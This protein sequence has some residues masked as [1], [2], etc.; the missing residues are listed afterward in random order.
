MVINDWKM[1]FDKY[2][3]LACTVPCD[4][5]SVLYEHGYIDDPYYGTNEDKLTALSRKDSVFYSEL[6]LNKE[7]LKCE[8]IDL[9]FY[10][11]D[12]ICDIYFNG[13][14]LDSVKNM[15]RMYEYDV[16]SLAKEKNEIKLYIKAPI[17]YFEKEEANH[18]LYMNDSDTLPGAAH[19][20][21]AFYM[22]GWD[23]A[24]K[25]PN[26][27][28][29]RPVTVRC[30]NTDK[31]EDVS[32]IQHHEDGF[33]RL[34]LSANTKHNSQNVK[35][36]CTVDGQVITLESGKG[37]AIIKNP[38][39]WWPNGYGK[40]E[41]YRVE[42]LMYENGALIDKAE[43]DIGLRTLCLSQEND[44]Y[45]Q[46]FCFKVNGVK[47][48]AMG[49]NYVPID[50]LLSRFTNERLEQLIKDCIFANFNCVRVWGGAFYP[51]DYFYEL[52]DKHGLIVWQDFMV[53]CANIWLTDEMEKEFEAEATYNIK[54]IRHHACLGLLCGNNEMEE[55]ICFWQVANGNDPLVRS[56]YLR[57]YEELLPK[58]C[59]ERAPYISY[60]PS[61]PTSGGGFN[62][63][64]DYTRGDVHFWNVWNGNC[65]LDEYRKHKFRFCSEY[66][67]ES[68]PS[69]KTVN[70]FCPR[71]EQN[72]LSYTMESHQKHWHGNVKL[73]K[74]MAERYLMPKDLETTVY[75]SQLNQAAAIQYGVE[76]FRRCRGYTMGSIYW[77][78]NDPWPVASW[79]SVDY[80]GRYKALHYFAKK[81]YQSVSLGLFNEEDKITVNVSNETMSQFN[82][83]IVAGVMKND[84]TPVSMHTR[85]VNVEALSSKD[86]KALSNEDFDGYNDAFFYAELYDTEN[87]LI[88]RNIELGKKPKHFKFLKPSIKI[89]AQACDEGVYLSFTSDVLAKNVFVSFKNHDVFLSDNFFDLSSKEPY[90]ILAKTDLSAKELMNSISLISVYDI[91]LR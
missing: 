32:I 82:G 63:P 74:Y 33:V 84:F 50:S 54:R 28:I 75:A 91:P 86:I 60:T 48:F 65:E 8:K 31:L 37:E 3:G 71:E 79:S 14:L 77:Q 25:L 23:W 89:D 12:T 27:G 66:G 34:E 49:A 41:L 15:H 30:Y 26:M 52:C 9:T 80:F 55:A 59:K 87:N 69:M 70:A 22:S 21:K 2:T 24:P 29:F 11:I 6:S 64:Q 61:S 88:A 20:R 47:I 78:L 51:D 81:F 73:I 40:Q 13:A 56:D 85:N 39:L 46:E 35:I 38:R 42:F 57:L 36:E 62:S 76:H 16:K 90:T 4:M 67:F 44:E 68:L 19:L 83:Y 5:Y 43:K 1:D 18:H 72:L 53:A 7:E 45:G 10:G 17:P 58:L